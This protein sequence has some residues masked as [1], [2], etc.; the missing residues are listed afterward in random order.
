MNGASGAVY[1]RVLARQAQLNMPSQ[2]AGPP[3]EQEIPLKVPKKTQLFLD[4]KAREKQQFTQMHRQF[5][6]DLTKLRVS[7]A[8]SYLDLL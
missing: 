7:T 4:L 6:K 5:Q 1:A 8:E 3:L 2:R